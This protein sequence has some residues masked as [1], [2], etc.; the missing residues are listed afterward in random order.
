MF[1]PIELQKKWIIFKLYMSFMLDHYEKNTCMKKNLKMIKKIKCCTFFD[2][3]LLGNNILT[4][5]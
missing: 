4:K 1:Y 3:I 2:F 5:L